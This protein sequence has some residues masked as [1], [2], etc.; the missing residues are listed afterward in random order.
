RMGDLFTPRP[1]PRSRRADRHPEESDPETSLG[2]SFNPL[3]LA[4]RSGES[5][6]RRAE[7]PRSHIPSSPFPSGSECSILADKRN[8][9]ADRKPKPSAACPRSAAAHK[10]M[11]TQTVNPSRQRRVRA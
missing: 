8:E 3:G 5:E 9:Y 2:G 7:P 10:G 1:Y 11:S 6:A 4:I